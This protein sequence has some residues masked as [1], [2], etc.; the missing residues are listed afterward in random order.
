MAKIRRHASKRMK[1]VD[2]P[3]RIGEHVSS[4][5]K[6]VPYESFEDYK[7]VVNFVDHYSRLGVCHFMGSKTEVLDCFK[8]I[9]L[10][11]CIMGT[12]LSIFTPIGEVNTSVKKVN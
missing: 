11:L 5:V 2:V 6:S 4:D 10:N 8:N 12:E 3:K 7:Y 1:Y 9:A